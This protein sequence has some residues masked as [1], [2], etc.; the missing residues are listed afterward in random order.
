MRLNNFLSSFFESEWEFKTQVR[1][2]QFMSLCENSI[3]SEEKLFFDTIAEKLR[4][5]YEEF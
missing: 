1:K 5:Q 3:S 4:F 2:N